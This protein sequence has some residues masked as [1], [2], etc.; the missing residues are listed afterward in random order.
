[1]SLASQVAPSA[2]GAEN[3]TSLTSQHV[4]LVH[5]V[6]RQLSRRLHDKVDLD[7]L[8]SAGSIGL[9]QAA[10]SYEPARG[11][12][13]STYAVPRIRGSMLDELR[14]HDRMS[15]GARKKARALSAARETLTRRLGREPRAAEIAAELNLSPGT[16]REWEMEVD[17]AGEISLDVA[18]RSLREDGPVTAAGAIPDER[19]PAI[20]ERIGHEERVA[21]LAIAIRCLRPQER[22]VLSLYFYEELTLQEIAHVLGLSASRISQIRA[23]ALAKLRTHLKSAL[24]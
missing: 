21:I 13:F 23:E 24:D 6:A 15:R 18:P 3:I 5:H 9:M 22:T 17:S 1:M 4:G 10:A 2:D 16:L 12:T 11:L 14:R 19:M 7:E 8:V 20:D